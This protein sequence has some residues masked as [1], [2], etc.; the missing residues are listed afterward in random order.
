MQ[1][2][3]VWGKKKKHKIKKMEIIKLCILFYF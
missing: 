1:I 2:F 3:I